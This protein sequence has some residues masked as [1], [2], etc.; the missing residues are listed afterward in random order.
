M[1]VLIS[2]AGL[3]GLACRLAFKRLGV[4]ADLIDLAPVIAKPEHDEPI[5]LTSNAT[6]VLH[7]LGL[8]GLIRS[9]QQVVSKSDLGK[10]SE[11]T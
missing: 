5:I 11:L 10:L 4:K 8:S 7:A 1:S 2:G 9:S 3:A 6:R